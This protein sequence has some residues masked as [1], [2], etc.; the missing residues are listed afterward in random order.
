MSV[1]GQLAQLAVN[2]QP[3]HPDAVALHQNINGQVI[4]ALATVEAISASSPE[5]T[6]LD[7]VLELADGS[8]YRG[9]SFGAPGKSI[10]G[11]CVFQTGE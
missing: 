3:A 6:N 7:A 2:G 1:N 10:A 11:E 5:S 4:H 8:I 9:V